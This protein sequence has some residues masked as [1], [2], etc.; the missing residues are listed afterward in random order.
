MEF[1]ETEFDMDR[2]MGIGEATPMTPIELV[3]LIK[4]QSKEEGTF[5]KN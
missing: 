5:A 4:K 3:S 2:E 1:S